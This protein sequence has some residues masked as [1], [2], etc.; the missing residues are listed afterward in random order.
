MSSSARV[1]IVHDLGKLNFLPAEDYGVLV[2]C[3]EGHVSPTAVRRAINLLQRKLTGI[4]RD[5]YIIASGHPALIAAA[6]AFQA[7]ATGN[8]RI[9]CWDNQT[10]RYALVE[11]VIYDDDS[12]GGD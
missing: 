12:G 4:T 10:Q 8:L 2:S 11:E 9:L 5:D 3:V 7:D 1:Y 6:G